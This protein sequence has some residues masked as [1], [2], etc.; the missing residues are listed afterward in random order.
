[1][2]LPFVCMEVDHYLQQKSEEELGMLIFDEQKEYFNEVERSLRT[3]RLDPNS[4]LKTTKIIEKGFFVDSSKSFPIQ[5][6][7]L[8]AYYVRKYEEHKLGLKVGDIDKQTFEVIDQLKSTGIGS[9]T[10]DI[11]E[12]VK[13]NHTK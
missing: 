4:I 8:V 5:L 7:D 11:W 9:N 6:T 10:G 3:L 12:W 1:M 2:A 13:S